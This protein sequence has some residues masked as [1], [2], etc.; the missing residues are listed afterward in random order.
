L[1][2]AAADELLRG[3]KTAARRTALLVAVKAVTWGAVS[4]LYKP[5]LGSTFFLLLHPERADKLN[6]K[7][8]ANKLLQYFFKQNSLNGTEYSKNVGLF[9]FQIKAPSS[10][11]R[12]RL[13]NILIVCLR[14]L[15]PS[16]LD[17]IFDLEPELLYKLES[18]MIN[19]LNQ[20]QNPQHL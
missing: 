16:R 12:L 13:L 6:S 11:A 17:C 1:G 3:E 14:R 10:L 7:H 19:Q 9:Q 15:S 5:G 20:P 4:D 8:P 2:A 18:I